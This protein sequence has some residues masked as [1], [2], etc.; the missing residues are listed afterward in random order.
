MG[1]D[2]GIPMQDCLGSSYS[3]HVKD[4]ASTQSSTFSN[5]LEAGDVSLPPAPRLRTIP[6]PE[7]EPIEDSHLEGPLSDLVD[8]QVSSSPRWASFSYDILPT[9]P[10]TIH[11]GNALGLE[12]LPPLDEDL[13]YLQQLPAV[14]TM[15]IILPRTLL[16]VLDGLQPGNIRSITQLLLWLILVPFILAFV[17]LLMKCLVRHAFG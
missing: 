15:V 12:L 9:S 8:H 5:C 13:D 10:T 4:N 3:E 2:S 1:N 7:L 6:L 14:D 16:E 11:S 17:K